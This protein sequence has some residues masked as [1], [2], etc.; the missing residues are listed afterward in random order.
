MAVVFFIV[1]HGFRG[2]TAAC[3]LVTLSPQFHDVPCFS[4]SRHRTLTTAP[5]GILGLKLCQ[6]LRA[7][8]IL[9]VSSGPRAL[10]TQCRPHF[11]LDSSWALSSQ[12]W[13]SSRVQSWGGPEFAW[14]V[15]QVMVLSSCPL[16]TTTTHNTNACGY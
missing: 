6:F 9:V 8:C 4:G 7:A 10:S 15:V 16:S 12:W 3:G 5:C 11:E 14:D 2:S 13:S 1:F